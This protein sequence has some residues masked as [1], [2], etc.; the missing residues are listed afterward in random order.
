MVSSVAVWTHDFLRVHDV[1]SLVRV[2]LMHVLLTLMVLG[3]VVQR[4]L[5]NGCLGRMPLRG[6]FWLFFAKHEL[7]YS[8][9]QEKYAYKDK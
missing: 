2:R 6:V 4:L 5:M 9:Q 8:N 3:C 1:A 7:Y